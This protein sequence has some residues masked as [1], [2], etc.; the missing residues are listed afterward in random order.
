MYKRR[1]IRN[2]SGLP[3]FLDGL[4]ESTGAAYYSLVIPSWRGGAPF[5]DSNVTESMVSYR[6]EALL[7][8]RLAA[9]SAS[10]R[11]VE[12]V[13]AKRL[14]PEEAV[15]GEGWDEVMVS[16][17]PA[18]DPRGD[19]PCS[20]LYLARKEE[21]ESL[22]SRI[23]EDLE[24]TT[25]ISWFFRVAALIA[26]NYNSLY[27]AVE[28]YAEMMAVHDRFMPFHM[29]IVANLGFRVAK[30]LGVSEDDRNILYLA[31]LMH[32]FG[33]LFVPVSIFTKEGTLTT[34]EM[35]YVRKHSDFGAEL[36]THMLATTPYYR[37]I[38]EIIRHHH[39]H[40]DGSGYPAGLKGENIPWLSRIMC[41]CDAIDAMET[42]KS[43][44][45]KLDRSAVV[46]EL[47]RCSGTQFDEKVV[48]AA[49]AE[50]AETKTEL[51]L[52]SKLSLVYIPEVTLVVT[53]AGSS[54]RHT[55][56]G[57]LMADGKG[58]KMK[59]DRGMDLSGLDPEKTDSA[60][61][62]VQEGNEM[63]EYDVRVKG[64]GPHTVYISEYRLD[65][66]DEVFSVIWVVPGEIL[67]L[68]REKGSYHTIA[69]E[70]YKIGGT[71][72]IVK[73]D[74]DHFDELKELHN[75]PTFFI[76][77]TQM[78]DDDLFKMQGEIKSFYRKGG[79][80]VV[81]GAFVN[82]KEADKDRLVRHM[83]KKQIEARKL[84]R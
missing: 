26:D 30:R 47:R 67:Y 5:T 29:S 23:G 44:R 39:E 77:K 4:M 76:F 20:Q 65:P 71:G 55:L 27:E 2:E 60:R 73:V 57:T 84:L 72:L 70:T 74:R 42:R 54:R 78:D 34:G 52:L 36:A 43:Y 10:C 1:I 59:V 58:L 79:E 7:A 14:S 24:M 33:K 37:D 81:V 62:L 49:L 56:E 50:L 12:V 48:E 35:V 53:Q 25:Q 16:I 40:V 69:F 66:L 45:D 68:D 8:A 6:L 9:D 38:P 18:R 31:A 21:K 64:A 32:D 11:T 46:E 13:T 83:F 15:L 82:V 63:L 80:V 41:V 51:D 75:A 22:A 28:M 61:M 19:C 17:C 3:E